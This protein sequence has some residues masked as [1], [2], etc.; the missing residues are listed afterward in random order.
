MG[1]WFSLAVQ[2]AIRTFLIPSPHTCVPTQLWDAN[3]WRH[4]KPIGYAEVCI[5]LVRRQGGV[6]YKA[7][8]AARG[9]TLH[10][11]SGCRLLVTGSTWT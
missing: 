6:S 4:D 3:R 10:R 5:S 9:V 8:T 11:G 2:L 1:F 7:G